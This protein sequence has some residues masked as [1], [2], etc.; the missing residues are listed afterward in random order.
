MENDIK[1]LRLVTGEDIISKVQY[2]DAEGKTF[3]LEKPMKVVYAYNEK[4]GAM[5]INLMTWIFPQ[6]ISEESSMSIRATDVLVTANV[7]DHMRKYYIA[8][9]EKPDKE[10]SKEEQEELIQSLRDSSEEDVLEEELTEEELEE[11]MD[12][13]RN[14][15]RNKRILH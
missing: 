14:T 13:I 4:F 6:L 11:A 12:L 9:L 15:G 8:L 10:P 3:M 7:S 1:F 5:A 2:I